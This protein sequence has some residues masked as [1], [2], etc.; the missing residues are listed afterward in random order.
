MGAI[1][2]QAMSSHWVNMYGSFFP[3]VCEGVSQLIAVD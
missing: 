2:R 3:D 1:E